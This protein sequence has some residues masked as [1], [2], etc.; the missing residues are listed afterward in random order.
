MVRILRFFHVCSRQCGSV[1]SVQV[2]SVDWA[3]TLYLFP[4]LDTH[5]HQKKLTGPTSLACLKKNSPVSSPDL[6]SGTC[7]D[8]RPGIV[9]ESPVFLPCRLSLDCAL[10]CET[11]LESV[12]DTKF[13][14]PKRGVLHRASRDARV[15]ER[16]SLGYENRPLS[17]LI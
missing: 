17:A 16:K 8:Y 11:R 9:R 13:P 2:R 4:F 6:D 1:L 14:R 5:P 7:L 15:L 10:N 12:P 3:R